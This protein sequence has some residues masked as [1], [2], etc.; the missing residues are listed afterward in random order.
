M[1]STDKLGVV[2]KIRC[3]HIQKR[4]YMGGR[5][6]CLDWWRRLIDGIQIEFKRI[7]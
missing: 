4:S 1:G 2:K 5:R 6:D 7:R 3:I